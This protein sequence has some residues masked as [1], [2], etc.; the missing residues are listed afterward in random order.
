LASVTGKSNPIRADGSVSG[1]QPRVNRIPEDDHETFIAG[2]PVQVVAGDVE[3]WDGVTIAAGIA[4]IAYEDAS[5]L[6]VAGTAETAHFGE[7]INEPAA[8]NIFRGAPLNDGQIGVEVAVQ[9]TLFHAQV[10]AATVPAGALSTHY[11]LTKDT[12]GHWYVDTAKV[13]TSGG[14]KDTVLQVVRLD[15]NDPRG[16]WFVFEASASQLLA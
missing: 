1:N 7:V 12:D 8:V 2:T 16:V 3:A 9:D 6:A 13:T 4:G 15:E 11:G 5:N 10:G 14:G